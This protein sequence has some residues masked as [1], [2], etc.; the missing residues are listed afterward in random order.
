M[1]LTIINVILLPAVNPLKHFS[2]LVF[3]PNL[4][5]FLVKYCLMVPSWPFRALQLPSDFQT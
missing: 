5:P 1:K 4:I 3:P 2:S